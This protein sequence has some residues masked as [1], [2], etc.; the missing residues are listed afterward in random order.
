MSSKPLKLYFITNNPDLARL[1]DETGIDRIMVDL[2]IRGKA[3]RQ[4]TCNTLISAHTPEDITRVRQ[5][6]RR[7]ELLTRVNP[8]WSGTADEVEDAL[9][10]GTDRFMLPMFQTPHDLGS[11]ARMVDGRV[12]ITGLLETRAAMENITEIIHVSGI[13]DFHVGLTDLHLELGMPFLFQCLA[14]GYIDRMAE[15]FNEAGVP[16]GFGGTGRIG[17]GRLPAELII[18]EHMRL[19]SRAVIL[20]RVFHNNASTLEELR[21]SGI[22]F[23]HEV[24]SVLEVASKALSRN[25]DQVE[26]DRNEVRRIVTGIVSER[27]VHAEE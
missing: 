24:L 22:D 3:E 27:R 9:Q 18:R 23:E 8:L 6:I 15:V 12:P 2:E 13:D 19:G 4:H 11:F 1:A 25:P 10:R 7:G 26:H 17:E 21:D 16:F 5:A 20:G 14:E